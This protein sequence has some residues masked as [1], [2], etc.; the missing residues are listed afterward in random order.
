[1]MK[2]YNKRLESKK[3][4]ASEFISGEQS[5]T[6]KNC[7]DE[8]TEWR[9]GKVCW[10]NR[11]DDAAMRS[12]AL[13]DNPD[14]HEIRFRACWTELNVAQ[15]KN[16]AEGFEW[17]KVFKFVFSQKVYTTRISYTQDIWS[18]WKD[19]AKD[20]AENW[21]IRR[22]RER[23]TNITR[24]FSHI[25]SPRFSHVLATFGFFYTFLIFFLWMFRCRQL[26]PHGGEIVHFLVNVTCMKTNL[27]TSDRRCHRIHIVGIK[28]L[29]VP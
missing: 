14:T 6:E 11:R 21:G 4:C 28:L 24:Q 19:N 15:T 26:A 10:G 17:G 3:I 23:M 8:T 16:R 20:L 25:N 12:R 5:W 1:M 18:E 22:R 13:H 2:M 27:S 29:N 7:D 9:G